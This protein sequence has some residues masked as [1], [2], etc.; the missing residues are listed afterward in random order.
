MPS[1]RRRL[2]GKG[3]RPCRRAPSSVRT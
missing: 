1:M 2:S 3:H